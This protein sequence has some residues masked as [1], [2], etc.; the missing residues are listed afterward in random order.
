MNRTTIY[1]NLFNLDYNT[2][3]SDIRDYFR[4]VE[5]L[6]INMGLIAKGVVDIKLRSKTEA[7]QIAEIGGG[8]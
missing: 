7:L 4:S 1:L 3:E 8:V 6:E 5:M 2:K